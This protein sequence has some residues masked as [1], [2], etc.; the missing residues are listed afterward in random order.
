MKTKQS[1]LGF[2]SLALAVLS[3]TLL[4][5]P[6]IEAQSSSAPI[7]MC[8]QDSRT[9]M[10]VV[11]DTVLVD[12][13]N[14]AKQVDASG[15]LR[16]DVLPGEHRILISAK[17]YQDLDT[18]QTVL[19]GNASKSII[20]LDPTTPPA[21]PFA[22]P[23]GAIG[24]VPRAAIRGYVVD[25]ETGQPLAGAT[26]A[27]VGTNDHTVT[28]ADGF[29]TLTVP[30]GDG[31]PIPEDN[32]GRLFVKK[33][34][35]VTK[36]GYGTLVEQNI[37]LIGGETYRFQFRLVPDGVTRAINEQ[38][39]RGNMQATAVDGR[40]LVADAAAATPRASLDTLVPQTSL[41]QSAP[42]TIRVGRTGCSSSP[43][44]CSTVVTMSMETYVKHVLPAEWFSSWNAESLK[45]GAVAIRSYGAYYVNHPI[46][47]SSSPAYDICD[48]A[49]CQVYG[50]STASSTDSAVDTTAGMYLVDGSGNIA[51]TEYSAENND[52][53][54]RDTCGD[55][56]IRNKP[57]DGIC[58]SDSVC[59]GQTQNGHGRGMCQWGSQRWASNQSKTYTWILGHYYD[60]YGYTLQSLAGG[61]V[62][63]TLY[64][65]NGSATGPLLVGARVNGTDGSGLWFDKTTGSGGYVTITG[66]P[67]SWYFTA[68]MSGYDPISW[69]PQS[70]TITGDKQAY[71]IPSP[72][73]GSLYVTIGPAGAISAGAQW[74]VDGGVWQSSGTTVSSLSVGS[75]TVTFLAVGGYTTPN[76]QSVTIYNGQT[77][78]TSGTY[79]FTHVIATVTLGSLSQTYDG[80]AKTAT[81]TTTPPGLTVNFTYNGSPNAPISAGSY[82]V[83]GTVN[84]PNYE[85]SA[86]DTLVIGKATATVALGSLSQTY[87]GAAKTATATTTPPGLTVNFTYNGSPNTPVNT[88]SYTVIGTVN[89]LNFKGSATDTLVIGEPVPAPVIT[90][91]E[92]N[93]VKPGG[94]L[95][96]LKVNGSGFVTGSVI[97]WNGTG[98]TTTFVDSYSLMAII[99][100]TL[101]TSSGTV[102]ITVFNPDIGGGVLSSESLLMI[103]DAAPIMTWE[104]TGNIIT[105]GWPTIGFKLQSSPVLPATN[106]QDVAGSETT[107]SWSVTIG[108]GNQFYRLE[109]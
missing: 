19:A 76:L 102:S 2:S 24:E 28:D 15:R 83:I 9:G 70:L 6:W 101:I 81:A 66:T 33:D 49:S 86:T 48:S 32:T 84:D 100:N 18:R 30:V 109:Q 104:H 5:V 91:L 16:L 89:D 63:L 99:N 68:S 53:G 52:L 20:L 74:E 38:K 96:I 92:P 80:T 25:D 39:H 108:A 42:S 22:E 90:T 27:V 47:P 46:S 1:A 98:L 82:T 41:A 40:P 103:A 64:V 21:E 26:L 58:L 54:N 79:T 11:P 45:A 31:T 75:H 85:G 12:D 73:S 105:L 65:H 4:W 57:G 14:V 87:N 107:N 34:M 17:G 43:G 61:T 93:Q 106:W 77:T 71:L 29:L 78:S 56:Y 59:C 69:G 55:C 51:Q 94:P 7:Q 95:F 50:N 67:G 62:T 23:P 13:T 36:V 37:V 60:A 97:R 10:G 3:A 35:V 8:F 88:G 44:A 72:Q